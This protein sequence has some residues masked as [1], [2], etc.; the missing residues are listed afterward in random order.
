MQKYIDS[1]KVKAITHQNLLL[2]ILAVIVLFVCLY[3][4]NTI[5]SPLPMAGVSYGNTSFKDN[6]IVG[7][8]VNWASY[9]WKDKAVYQQTDWIG[10]RTFYYMM[11][12]QR[13]DYSPVTKEWVQTR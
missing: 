8:V 1:L 13:F 2:K 7:G 10:R 6:G 5:T 4:Y 11:D 12:G 9:G 3:A